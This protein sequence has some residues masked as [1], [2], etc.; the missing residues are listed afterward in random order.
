MCGAPVTG[1]RPH[2]W[3]LQ[4]QRPAEVPALRPRLRSRANSCKSHCLR[5]L[6]QSDD[7]WQTE[8]L[9]S[10]TDRRCRLHATSMW[11]ML[12]EG[13]TDCERRTARPP[14]NLRHFCKIRNTAVSTGQVILLQSKRQSYKPCSC[15]WSVP[16]T[17]DSLPLALS[18]PSS[19]V[20][21]Q[22]SSYDLGHEFSNV[23]SSAAPDRLAMV[24]GC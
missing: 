2:I 6:R 18:Q 5:D 22:E 12:P 11:Q 23:I 21:R 13:N 17:G 8:P 24:P 19:A 9:A 7:P 3:A 16:R 15:R 10:A 1:H 20:L 4:F 14:R